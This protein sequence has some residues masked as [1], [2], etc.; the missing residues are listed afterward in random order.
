MPDGH[1]LPGVW[2]E[3]WGREAVAKLFAA[4]RQ[5]PDGIF[6][7]NDQIARGAIDA[8]AR[9]GDRGAANPSPSSASIIGRLSHQAT[10]PP[11]T[12]VDMNLKE[13]G[14]EAG[15]LPD[16][17]DRRRAAQRRTPAALSSRDTGIVQRR[18]PAG[19]STGR[20]GG[21]NSM[22]AKPGNAKARPVRVS[23]K[24]AA[25]REF[26]PVKFTDVSV[27]GDFWRERLDT[28]LTRTIPS[29][30]ARLVEYG[31]LDSLDV[32]QPPPPLRIPRNELTISPPRSSGI[33][34]SA[35]GSRRRATRLQ[36][37]RDATIEAQIDANRRAARQGAAPRWL[38]EL[39]VY[40]PRDRQALDQPPRQSR[41]L[42]RRPHAGRR[43]RL[44][45]GDRPPQPPRRHAALCRSYCRDVRQ[46]W[47]RSA[48]IA[49][50][51]RSS[52]L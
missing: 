33:P 19:A 29:Q 12:S 40:R 41:A 43:R 2:T 52:S 48:A 4:S 31:I 36:H 14:R 7:G 46:G 5:P 13:L 20:D 18:L 9:A 11:L 23:R 49:A 47:A 1:Y 17:A 51:R 34:T 21:C 27:E 16:R 26:T 50:I 39:L 3:E 28:V 10:R 38:S 45:Q 25:M 15:P 22:T 42:L 32:P 6:C 8:T 44:F 37:R 35:S 30:H 24:E